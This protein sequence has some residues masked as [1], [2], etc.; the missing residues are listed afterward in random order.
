MPG[1]KNRPE[2]GSTRPAILATRPAA[3]Q[4]R[5]ACPNRAGDEIWRPGLRLAEANRT[6]TAQA[7]GSAMKDGGNNSGARSGKAAKDQR[8]ARLKQAL[9][10]NLKRRKSQARERADFTPASSEADDVAR[11]DGGESPDK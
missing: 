1:I 6:V 9:R 11:N 3:A 8:E 2:N 5:G 10:E 7:N 4:A